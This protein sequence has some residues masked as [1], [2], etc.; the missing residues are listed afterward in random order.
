MK[1]C[2]GLIALNFDIREVTGLML[3]FVSNGETKI[4]K[5]RPYLHYV[6]GYRDAD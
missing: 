4:T 3:A 5:C 2:S 6:R 1:Y